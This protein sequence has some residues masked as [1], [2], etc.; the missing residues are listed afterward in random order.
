MHVLTNG[1]IFFFLENITIKA[2]IYSI[3][4]IYCIFFIHLSVDG[5]LGY[6]HIFTIVNN[7]AMNME[8]Q[9]SLQVPDFNSFGCLLR[10]GISGSY[11]RCIY[12]FL[13]NF[14]MVFHRCCTILHSH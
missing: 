1:R 7:D 6:F 8:V 2:E 4:R 11:S 14:H 3:V 10:N 5:H 12:K 9:I 13:R